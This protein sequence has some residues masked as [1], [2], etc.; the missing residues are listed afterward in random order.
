MLAL[1]FP[2]ACTSICLFIFKFLFAFKGTSAHK[3]P[4]GGRQQRQ[5]CVASANTIKVAGVQQCKC[6][7]KALDVCV[8]VTR[9]TKTP[10]GAKLRLETRPLRFT[11]DDATEDAVTE[12]STADSQKNPQ[13][14]ITKLHDLKRCFFKVFLL[15]NELHDISGTITFP[16]LLQ[17][18][19][20]KEPFCC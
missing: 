10:P 14:K 15:L 2:W 7:T 18:P 16:I 3:P 1:T 19:E 20:G 5:K 4:P 8:D 13:N 12:N 11:V 6:E 17:S 9:A